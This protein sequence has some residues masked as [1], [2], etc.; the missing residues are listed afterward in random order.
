MDRP[1]TSRKRSASSSLNAQPTGSI[2]SISPPRVLHS[3]TPRA[4]RRLPP[5]PSLPLPRRNFYIV[6]FKVFVVERQRKNEARIH[7]SAKHFSIE[8]GRNRERKCRIPRISPPPPP[9]LRF[10]LRLRLQKGGV[11]VGHYE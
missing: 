10:V 11:F 5:P 7:R 8:G 9:P 4:S 2:G 6:R 3:T 1:A